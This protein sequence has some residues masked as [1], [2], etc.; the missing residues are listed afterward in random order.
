MKDA[1]TTMPASTINATMKDLAG[2]P[3]KP[4]A[5]GCLRTLPYLTPRQTEREANFIHESLQ[6]PPGGSLL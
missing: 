1:S 2:M 5:P 6:L 3:G 4:P